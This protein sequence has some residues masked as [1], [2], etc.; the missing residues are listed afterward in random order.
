MPVSISHHIRLLQAGN[1]SASSGGGNSTQLDELAGKLVNTLIDVGQS[2]PVDALVQS[3]NAITETIRQQ[4]HPHSSTFELLSRLLVIA[5]NADAVSL[6]DSHEEITGVEFR[7]FILDRICTAPWNPKS[8]LPLATLLGDVDME[9]K[10]LEMAIVKVMKQFKH[11]DATDLPHLIYNLLLLSS[12]V[13][14][15]G[16][17]WRLCASYSSS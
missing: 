3:I 12:K 9:S 1:D 11:I 4:Q 7:D 8:V 15:L 13:T 14:D 5:A 2:F 6:P 17:E 10:Q 16:S